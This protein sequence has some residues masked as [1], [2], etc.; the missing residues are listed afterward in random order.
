[1]HKQLD[2]SGFKDSSVFYEKQF[3]VILSKM[4]NCYF[5]MKND[6]V[7]LE[8]DENAI[9]DIFLLNYL[10]NNEVRK[11]LSLTDWIFEREVQED[12]SAGRTDIKIISHDTFIDQ[13]AYYIIECKRLDNNRVSGTT[14][15]NAEY[16]KN[17]VCRFTTKYYSMYRR[18]NGMIGFIVEKMDIDSNMKK[19]TDLMIETFKESRTIKPILQ[20]NFIAN[21]EFHYRSNHTDTDNRSLKL[22]HLMFDFHDNIQE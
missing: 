7:V 16:V 3:E 14:G 12:H 13:E 4:V 2:A 10:K 17:G 18:V 11:S 15:L 20:D 19:I 8:N 1:M 22:Y 5:I 9:R 21:F 6:S